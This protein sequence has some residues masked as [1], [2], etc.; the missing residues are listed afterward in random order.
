[1]VNYNNSIIYKLCCNDTSITDIYVGSTTNFNRRKNCHKSRCNNVN[2]K[3]YNCKVYQFIRDNGGWDNWDMV[4]VCRVNCIDRRE[5]HKK[6]REQIE[7]LKPTL[8]Q[9]IPTRTVKEYQ[10]ANKEHIKEYK[11]E[12]NKEYREDNK[13]HIKEYKKDYYEN[14]KEILNQKITCECGSIYMKQCKKRHEKSNKHKVYLESL[15][16]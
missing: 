16:S 11:K 14:N 8:N 5:L 6:E 3:E 10:Q 2:L 15:N 1:M 9:R 13:E 7:L 4:E 12:Y